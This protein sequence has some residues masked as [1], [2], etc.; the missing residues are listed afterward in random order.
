MAQSLNPAIYSLTPHGPNHRH[1]APRLRLRRAA[2]AQADR[3]A[4]RAAD[5]AGVDRAERGGEEHADQALARLARAHARHDP[6]RWFVAEGCDRARG[7]RRL[8]AAESTAR[9]EYAT[10]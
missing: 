7:C 2:W 1:L 6:H 8:L 3:S 5:D 4:R 9:D 10:E